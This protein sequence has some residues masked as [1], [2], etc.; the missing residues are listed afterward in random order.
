MMLIFYMLTVKNPAGQDS[1]IIAGEKIHISISVIIA[2]FVW[3]IFTWLSSRILSTAYLNKKGAE[4]SFPAYNDFY[5]WLLNVPRILAYFIPV[6]LQIAAL[7]LPVFSNNADYPLILVAGHL[8]YFWVFYRYFVRKKILNLII[9]LILGSAYLVW[10]MIFMEKTHELAAAAVLNW[11]ILVLFFFFMQTLLIYI[12][13]K[14]DYNYDDKPSV[15]KENDNENILV[16]IHKKWMRLY[17]IFSL[18]IIIFFTLTIIFYPA[19]EF[20]GTISILLTAMGLWTGLIYLINF[21]II[22]MKVNLWLPILLYIFITGSIIDRY[23]VDTIDNSGKAPRPAV[24]EFLDNWINDLERRD[25]IESAKIFPVYL[26]ISDGGASRS[27]YWA[28]KILAELHNNVSDFPLHLLSL[29]GTSG[30]SVGNS[31]YYSFLKSTSTLPSS[32]IN[33][34]KEMDDFF[35]SDFLSYSFSHYLGSDLLWH[36]IP[37]PQFVPDRAEALEKSMERS[38]SEFISSYFRGSLDTVF[39]PNS[40]LPLLIIN[41]THLNT[42]RPAVISNARLNG[43]SNRK[44]ILSLIEDSLG[45]QIKL[46]TAVI[47]GARFPYISPA[48][49]IHGESFVDGGYF[50]NS[51]GGITQELLEFIKNKM[52]DSTENNLW[53]KYRDKLKFRV[54]HLSNGSYSAPRAA[55]VSSGKAVPPSQYIAENLP[56]EIERQELHP[57]LN[58][59]AAPLLTVIGTYISQTSY[60]NSRLSTYMRTFEYRID[61]G[62]TRFNLPIREDGIDYP[63]NWVI[64]EFNLERI[65]RKAEGIDIRKLQEETAVDYD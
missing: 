19:S 44:D 58:D 14:W 4:I 46:S 27:G 32:G 28:G 23:L 45:K 8:L 49:N 47:I 54:I 34:E 20:I 63:I 53:H 6:I 39:H 24:N 43:V 10:C 9:A 33:P 38:H 57:L 41:S 16:K 30:G 55:T 61:N 50:D 18:V 64:S 29:S 37:F 36:G 21:Q 26:V 7:S 5:I 40:K 65:R 62:F 56:P 42:G 3:M 13:Y 25:K 59:L 35:S 15:I 11:K 60:S 17:N 22:K 12:F 48:G 2:A 31:A 52:A 1:L 51:G